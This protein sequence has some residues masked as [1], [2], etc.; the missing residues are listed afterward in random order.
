MGK[1]VYEV[2]VFFASHLVSKR[3]FFVAFFL[4][5]KK[6]IFYFC[7]L[8][9]KF[10]FRFFLNIFLNFSQ[11]FPRGALI[12]SQKTIFFLKKKFFLTQFIDSLIKN[13]TF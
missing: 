3:I 10:F 12:F 2:Q 8:K 6:N 11:I 9:I 4:K 13:L 5:N 7:L 1:I